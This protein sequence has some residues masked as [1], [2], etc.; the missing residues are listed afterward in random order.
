MNSPLRKKAWENEQAAVAV[1]SE[2]CIE[3]DLGGPAALD[4]NADIRE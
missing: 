3:E 4:K 1:A 2:G